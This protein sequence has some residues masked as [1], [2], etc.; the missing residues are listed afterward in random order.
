MSDG[1]TPL[2]G[3]G[4]TEAFQ[5]VVFLIGEGAQR[6]LSRHQIVIFVEAIRHVGWLPC[7][8]REDG[9]RAGLIPSSPRFALTRCRFPAQRFQALEEMEW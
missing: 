7:G 8:T 5:F 4:T 2:G 9:E 3:L 1:T 6:A